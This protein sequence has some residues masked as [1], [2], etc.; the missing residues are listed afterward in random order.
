MCRAYTAILLALS[1]VLI[2]APV[3]RSQEPLPATD[4]APK[5]TQPTVPQQD[6]TRPPDS[7]RPSPTPP[8]KRIEK[9]KRTVRKIGIG[10]KITVFLNNGDELHGAVSQI[11]AES[12]QVA[13]I[14]LHQVFTLQYKY[15][16]KVRSGYG[17]INLLTGKR[18][19]PPR[20]VKIGVLV[21][22]L[23]ALA[24]PI[25]LLMVALNDKDF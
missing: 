23:A 12:F 10:S 21:G 3:A 25:V 2:Q 6:Q 11:D 19:S 13:E 4:Q 9:I 5:Q 20:G 8:D 22:S 24:L 14:D 7:S 18:T 1:L 16:K 17:G 15:V